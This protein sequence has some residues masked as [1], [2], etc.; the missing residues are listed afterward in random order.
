MIE[1]LILIKIIV[2]IFVVVSLSLVAENVSPKVAGILAGYPL[3]TAIVLFFVGIENGI[4][5]AANSAIYALGGLSASLCF[6]YIYYKVSSFMPKDNSVSM[7][8]SSALSI[9]GFLCIAQFF[10][11]ISLSLHE[12]VIVIILAILLFSFL[13]RKI[14]NVTVKAKVKITFNVI[15]FR[16]VTASLIVITI[17]GVAGYLG[18]QWTGV[19]SGFPITL[20]PLLLVIHLTYGSEQVHTIIKNFPNGMGAL[21]VYVVSVSYTYPAFGVYWGTVICFALATVYLVF[22]TIINSIRASKKSLPSAEN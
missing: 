3:G 16:A 2:S 11:Q 21:I 7:L 10:S 8:V 6:V 4:T 13:F 17:T 19:L 20:Y 18:E 5:F 15:L 14:D 22:Y 9:F 1:S 12:G